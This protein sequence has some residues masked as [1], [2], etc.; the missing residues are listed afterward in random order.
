LAASRTKEQAARRVAR[1]PQQAEGRLL[2]CRQSGA[3]GLEL[4]VLVP[5]AAE[6]AD[7]LE[8][9]AVPVLKCPKLALKPLHLR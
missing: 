6:Q 9:A 4:I 2:V 7:L 8:G 3:V 5:A 1:R